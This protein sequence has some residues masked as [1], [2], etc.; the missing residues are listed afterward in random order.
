MGVGNEEEWPP[1]RS[2]YRHRPAPDQL[3]AVLIDA[4]RVPFGVDVVDISRSGAL[5]RLPRSY[6]PAVAGTPFQLKLV[7][8]SEV[9]AEVRLVC[10]VADR[11]VPPNCCAVI[12]RLDLLHRFDRSIEDLLSG[13]VAQ[14]Q[15][16]SLKA[17]IRPPAG[18]IVDRREELEMP[19]P[20]DASADEASPDS[21]EDVPQTAQQLTLRISLDPEA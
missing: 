10:T 20:E 18:S 12:F 6:P 15:R 19:P 4:D 8:K 11:D 5:L 9:G 21:P 13:W 2:A 17:G 14:W 1:S 3:A 16:Q 7:N